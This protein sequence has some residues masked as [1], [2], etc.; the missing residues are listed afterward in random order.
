VK[1]ELED[2]TCGQKE[3]TKSDTHESSFH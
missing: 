1:G 3:N 2:C